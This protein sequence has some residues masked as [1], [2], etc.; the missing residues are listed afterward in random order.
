MQCKF[1]INNTTQCTN[2]V[3]GTTEFCSEHMNYRFPKPKT[4]PVCFC[5]IHQ[6]IR[7]L[8]CHHWVHRSCVRRSGKAECPICREK[9]PD[10]RNVHKFRVKDPLEELISDP[11]I[12]M[13]E[14]PRDSIIFAVIAFKLYANL[15]HPEN[16][17]MGL[18]HFIRGVLD[19]FISPDHPGHDGI[20][21]FLYAEALEYF[22]NPMVV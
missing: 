22:F 3:R 14:I 21:S 6:C 4:C 11:S 7:P 10:I 20:A 9:L 5:S 17:V 2:K 19:V 13:V 16:R 18:D 15:I 1:S 12:E 8:A